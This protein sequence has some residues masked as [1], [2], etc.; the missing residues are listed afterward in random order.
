MTLLTTP[1]L[2]KRSSRSATRLVSELNSE[3]WDRYLIRGVSINMDDSTPTGSGFTNPWD[4]RSGSRTGAVQFSLTNTRKAP[5]L[6]V[7]TA[8][9]GA[10]VAGGCTTSMGVE[11]CK[12]YVFDHP[13]GPDDGDENTRR[14]DAVLE[15][16]AGAASDG[17]DSPA[18]AGV[19]FTGGKGD[20]AISDPYMAI[21]GEPLDAMVQNLGRANNSYVSANATNKV[22]SQGF[23]TGLAPRG[24]RL[25]GIGVNIEGSGS[26]YPDG[27]TSVS[28]AVHA[29]SNGQPGAKLVDLVS[30]TEYAAGHSFFE[31]PPGT[32]LR[33]STSYVLVW[34]HLGGTVH[35]LRKTASNG[36]DAGALVAFSIANAFY[37]GA[38]V[39]SLSEHSGGDA[40]EIAAYGEINTET[41]VYITPPHPAAP[42]AP[43]RTG[44]DRRRRRHPQVLRLAARH[45]PHV[46][47]RPPP[48]GDHRLVGHP[49]GG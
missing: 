39:G 34:S 28:V 23:T 14:R 19:S 13:I 47:R 40:L 25:Q 44:R 18:A 36:E 22:V 43:I 5:G 21:L 49:D 24:Y 29:N 31:A 11:T 3:Q 17:V 16:V 12:K 32:Y 38:T 46:R 30:P 4:L 37:R 41:V 7:W 9:Q 35:R 45:V 6:P 20:V 2:I 15:R 33:G 8:P 48:G 1:V 27:P 10:T 26:N 42:A